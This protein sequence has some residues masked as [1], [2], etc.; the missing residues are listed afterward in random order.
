[1]GGEFIRYDQSDEGKNNDDG[2]GDYDNNRDRVVFLRL[3]LVGL[4]NCDGSDR[5]VVRD[6]EEVANVTVSMGSFVQGIQRPHD[7]GAARASLATPIWFNALI[8]ASP[9]NPRRR[10]P[11][12]V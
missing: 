11:L 8:L 9:C 1:M 6:R 5:V 10:V 4:L 2:C 7:N 12:R 3:E